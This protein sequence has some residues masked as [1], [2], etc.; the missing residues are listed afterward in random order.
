MPTP[1]D[2]EQRPTPLPSLRAYSRPGRLAKGIGSTRG[3][4]GLL[5]APGGLSGLTLVWPWISTDAS[6]TSIA[7]DQGR[8]QS[9]QGFQSETGSNALGMQGSTGNACAYVRGQAGVRVRAGERVCAWREDVC[10][11][12]C[13]VFPLTL[14]MVCAEVRQH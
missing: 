6:Q 11:F 2:P 14:W 5:D 8:S 10:V 9:Y 13:A 7:R 1:L 12:I 4:R 3:Q